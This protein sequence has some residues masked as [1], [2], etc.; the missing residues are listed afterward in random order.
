[1]PAAASS[2]ASIRTVA[3]AAISA[4][5][6]ARV[7]RSGEP[8]CRCRCATGAT[9]FSPARRSERSPASSTALGFRVF[10]PS[11]CAISPVGERR[12][13]NASSWRR[14][15]ATRVLAATRPRWPKRSTSSVGWRLRGGSPPSVSKSRLS[16]RGAREPP[17]QRNERMH[18]NRLVVP[19]C[20]AFWEGTRR[21]RRTGDGGPAPSGCRSRRRARLRLGTLSRRSL[22]SS[23]PTVATVATPASGSVRVGCGG[24]N[25]VASPSRRGT[26]TGVAYVSTSAID[27]RS[28]SSVSS[29]RPIAIIPRRAYPVAVAAIGSIGGPAPGRCCVASAPRRDGPI[30]AIG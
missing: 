27:R 11:V 17:P 18:R 20:V 6:R 12:G 22:R 10:T 8:G 4:S 19:S 7:V 16:K 23:T 13:A 28:V 9:S 26:A 3:T 24:A 21:R 30:A 14:C 1:M 5:R 25:V 15:P 2:C 29:W